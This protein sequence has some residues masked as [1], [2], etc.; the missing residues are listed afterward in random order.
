MKDNLQKVL[1]NLQIADEMGERAAGT[2]DI[3]RPEKVYGEWENYLNLLAN[4][5]NRR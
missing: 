3:Y 4:R 2:S 5:K 1:N